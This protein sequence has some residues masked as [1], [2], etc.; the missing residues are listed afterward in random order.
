[1]PKLLK[2]KKKS[3]KLQKF[4][5]AKLY[6]SIKKSGASA[7][8]AK[9]VANAVAKK[10]KNNMPTS[11]IRGMVITQLGK[12]NKIIAASYKSHSKRRRR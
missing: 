10:V 5:K 11:K 4:S 3:G 12:H 9:K 7:E 1:M 8:L 2:V 6:R